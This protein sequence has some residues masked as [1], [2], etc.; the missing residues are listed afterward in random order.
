MLGYYFSP[1]FTFSSAS[2]IIIIITFLCMIIPQIFFPTTG[3][4]HLFQETVLPHL[5]LTP[6][7]IKHVSHKY[8]YEAFTS[9]FF[10][11]GYPHWLSNVAGIILN[12][13]TM[14]FCWFPSL[15]FMLL[16]GVVANCYATLTAD[17]VML[18]F[19][20]VIACSIGLYVGMFIG[21]WSYIRR[22]HS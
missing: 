19:S 10:H 11:A 16:G 8:I 12:M 7:E 6:I 2:F 4:T 17:V 9:M 20:G 21:N 5:Y 18:G 13:A 1:Y 3:Y 15:L 22:N 14:E